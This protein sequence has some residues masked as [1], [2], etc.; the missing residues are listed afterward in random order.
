MYRK[1]EQALLPATLPQVP[2]HYRLYPHTELSPGLIGLGYEALA[3]VLSKYSTI[4]LEG[5]SGVLWGE[6]IGG[7]EPNL[8]QLGKT[9]AWH[10]VRQALKNKQDIDT[11]ISPYLG[12][13]P[14]FG[15]RYPGTLQDFFDK[16]KLGQIRVLPD[17][18]INIVYGAGASLA[19]WQGLEVFLEVPKNEIQFRARAGSI[20]N[21]TESKATDSKQMYKHFYF[22]DWIVLNRHKEKLLNELDFVVDTQR[23]DSPTFM[24]GTA[25]RQALT[26]QTTRPL[27][28]RPW[29]EPGAWGGQVLKELIPELP[30]SVPNY[31]WSFEA[32]VPENGIIFSSKPSSFS[33]DNRL[34][35][36][37]F[38]WLM[39][40]HSR[41]VLGH[42]EKRFGQEFPI[43]F[44]FLDTFDGGNLSLQCHPSPEYIKTQFGETITQDETYYILDSK[45]NAQVYLGFHEDID[46]QKF[47]EVLEQSQ[48]NSK[49]IEV[50]QFVQ[51]HPANKHELFLIPHGTVHASGKNVLV[52]E[53]S[54]TP[55]IFTF[56]VY[57]WLRL[58]LDGKPRPINISRA[59]ENLNF[60]RK[61]DKVKEEH[62]A[63]AEV[64]EK[65]ETYRVVH[66][67]THPDHFYDVHRLEF[68]G[69]ISVQCNDSCH[70]LS[71]VEGGSIILEAN[72]LRQRY[73]YIETIIIP[74]A[75]KE[76]RLIA[77]NKVKVIKA[78][79]KDTQ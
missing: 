21:L 57:D 10:N 73:Y 20:S 39:M 64:I 2:E 40:Q 74:A 56:K 3:E 16:E 52:L 24:T 43:R 6:F 42:H 18:D 27:R 46:P 12:D 75:L 29:F 4:I 41:D 71:L 59:F 36:I 32:I 76:Y 48:E 54:A 78:F 8:K 63:K 79:L 26:E 51:T 1:T 77:E 66:L 14:V 34:L 67:A 47:R 37:S 69:E 61:G 22:L 13:D 45:E 53:I 25:F 33:S 58:D 62:I 11:M 49:P 35:E 17:A 44:D 30:R 7:L 65:G 28:V 60:E 5:Y 19:G 68:Q 15:T 72:G 50:E 31:A 70:V 9:V 55:Y 23:P 38:D